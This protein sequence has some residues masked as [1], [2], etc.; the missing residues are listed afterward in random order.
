MT[1]LSVGDGDFEMIRTGLV[2]TVYFTAVTSHKVNVIWMVV[3][4]APKPPS[5]NLQYKGT[6]EV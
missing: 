5:F 1:F 2:I 3:G 4:G 6:Y